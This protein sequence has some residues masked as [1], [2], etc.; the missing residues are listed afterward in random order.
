MTVSRMYD[1]KESGVVRLKIVSALISLQW[2]TTP[3]HSR[4]RCWLLSRWWLQI[5][6]I[7]VVKWCMVKCHLPSKTI[8]HSSSLASPLFVR[9]TTPHL[10]CSYSL[11]QIMAFLNTVFCILHLSI[12]DFLCILSTILVCKW[13]ILFYGNPDRCGTPILIELD[14]RNWMH[15]NTLV[16][17]FFGH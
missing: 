14:F 13:S 6:R 7:W 1:G 9:N 3:C 12:W 10:K 11:G 16:L 15:T 5:L 8:P 2:A 4:R 17:E